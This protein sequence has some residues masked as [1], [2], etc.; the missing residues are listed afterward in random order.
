[1]FNIK[2]KECGEIN[3]LYFKKQAI[4][5]LKSNM[6]HVFFK[7]T[8]YIS[9]IKVFN[10]SKWNFLIK[11]NSI[12]T[13]KAQEYNII[14]GNRKIDSSDKCLNEQSLT[15]IWPM[16]LRLLKMLTTFVLFI[17]VMRFTSA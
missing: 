6:Y 16:R 10:S 3:I 17:I 2:Y 8:K 12:K 14:T 7:I 11:S 4:F 5:F 1:M 9:N 15:K 13:N